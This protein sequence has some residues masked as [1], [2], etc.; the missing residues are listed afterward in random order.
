MLTISEASKA[1]LIRFTILYLRCCD[2][3]DPRKMVLFEKSVCAAGRQKLNKL[4]EN[5]GGIRAQQRSNSP[6]TDASVSQKGMGGSK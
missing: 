5:A 4:E 2:K 6:S 3:L 1:L